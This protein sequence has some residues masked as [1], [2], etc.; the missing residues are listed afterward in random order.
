MRNGRLVILLLLN[1]S[2]RY[3]VWLFLLYF[4][5]IMPAEIRQEIATIINIVTN[6]S[7]LED[8]EPEKP[9]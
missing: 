9:M 1:E 4:T 3:L 8:M 7:K 2:Q 5:N 6:C